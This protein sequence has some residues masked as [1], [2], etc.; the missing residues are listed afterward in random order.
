MHQWGLGLAST[1][2]DAVDELDDIRDT[3]AS[4]Y[5][6]LIVALPRLGVALAIVLV[7]VLLGRGARWGLRRRFT[8]TRS[9]SFAEVMSRV[10]GSVVV[11]VAVLVALTVT[12][13]SVRPVD[14]LASLGFFSIAIGFAFQDILENTLA[15]ILLLFRQ[16]FRAGDQID[17]GGQRGT[18]EGITIRE[19]RLRTFDGELLIVPNAE[20]YKNRLLVQT[21]HPEKRWAFVVGVGYDDDLD[22]ARNAAITAVN[23]VPEVLAT[24]PPRA[25]LVELGA[26]TIN[27]EV[28]FWTGSRQGDGLQTRDRVIDAVKSAMDHHGI[29]MP[30]EIIELAATR[31]LTS[32]LRRRGDDTADPSGSR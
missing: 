8:R 17:L 26:S 30:A 5:E 10:G 6:S 11:V 18:V 22:V 27:I 15:G 28:Q 32:A 21:A 7:G 12:F 2:N 3:A 24:P 25:L 31:S 29:S 9:P 20:V 23:S 13:P 14:V 19:T 4:L 16:P 1:G